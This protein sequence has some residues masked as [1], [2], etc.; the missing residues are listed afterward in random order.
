MPDRK[1]PF[2][3]DLPVDTPM[4]YLLTTDSVMAFDT[5][6]DGGTASTYGA[7]PAGHVFHK[8]QSHQRRRVPLC[9]SVSRMI[10]DIPVRS[11]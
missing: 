8:S 1:P 10:V 9:G 7:P 3:Q 6:I 5:S 11:K 4:G 2:F